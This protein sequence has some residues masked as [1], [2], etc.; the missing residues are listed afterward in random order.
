MSNQSKSYFKFRLSLLKVFVAFLV[1]AG[2]FSG[3]KSKK[4]SHHVM[5][6]NDLYLGQDSVKDNTPPADYNSPNQDAT[7]YGVRPIE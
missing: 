7:R 3:C 1:F 4:L 5:H 2:V 6:V